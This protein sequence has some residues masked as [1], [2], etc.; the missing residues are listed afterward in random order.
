M[1]TLQ[2]LR[3]KIDTAA[4]LHSVVGTMKTLA[5]VSIRQYERAVESLADFYRTIELGFQVVLHGSSGPLERAAPTGPTGMIVF[6]TDQGMCGQFNE[7]VISYVRQFPGRGSPAEKFLAVGSRVHELML[8]ARI[9]PDKVFAV[10]T[11]VSEITNFVLEILP[12]VERWQSAAQVS[13]I[14]V[15]H[16]TRTKAAAYRC[17]H[18]QLWPIDQSS[19]LH[20]KQARWESRSL[21]LVTMEPQQ[22]LSRI[23]RQHLFVVLFQACAESLASENASRITAM[24]AAERN[25]ETRLHDLRTAFNQL[26]QTQITEELLDVVTGFEALEGR[27]RLPRKRPE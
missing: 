2:G 27:S 22:L 12:Q 5:A 6:G 4:D 7:E 1:E 18:S 19:Y 17:R 3:R 21:P 13:R 25:I 20:W 10:P 15:F 11:S 14:L 16:N 8:D 26:R 23:I 9:H 24:Q